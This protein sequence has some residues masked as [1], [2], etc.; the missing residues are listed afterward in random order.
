L[1]SGGKAHSRWST[2]QRNLIDRAEQNVELQST[3]MR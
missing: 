2:L 1:L 3:N